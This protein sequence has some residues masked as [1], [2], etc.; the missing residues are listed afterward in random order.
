MRRTPLIIS[1]ALYISN[2][3]TESSL[4]LIWSQLIQLNAWYLFMFDFNAIWAKNESNFHLHSI[5]LL[6]VFRACRTNLMYNIKIFVIMLYIGECLID[7]MRSVL[8]L[9]IYCESD[10]TLFFLY[11]NIYPRFFIFCHWFYHK[12]QDENYILN[13]VITRCLKN[14]VISNLKKINWLGNV[15]LTCIRIKRRI[16]EW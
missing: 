2:P 5:Y 3:P 15:Q 9:E 7:V 1:L 12:R 8:I 11:R 4:Q 14:I 10:L 6:S 13:S 16:T